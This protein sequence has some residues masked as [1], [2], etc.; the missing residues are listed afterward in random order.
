MSVIYYYDE[1]EDYTY[2]SIIAESL[3]LLHM[4]KEIYEDDV[5]NTDDTNIT[6]RLK[7]RIKGLKNRI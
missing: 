3:D 7:I 1:S 6:T 2:F 4:L 5:I